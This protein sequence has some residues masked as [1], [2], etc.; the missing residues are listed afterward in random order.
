MLTVEAL[1]NLYVAM[2]G[3]AAAVANIDLNPEAVSAIAALVESGGGTGGG[4]AAYTVNVAFDNE[5]H[6]LT[7]DKGAADI[8]AAAQ[9][10]TVL[11]KVTYLDGNET[12]TDVG[13][14]LMARRSESLGYGDYYAF[15]FYVMETM[16]MLNGEGDEHPSGELPH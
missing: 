10:G 15:M 6:T 14:A 11:F 9:N 13:N 12:V 1:K 5:T 16:V 4:S 7:A 2:G 3:D 8:Y